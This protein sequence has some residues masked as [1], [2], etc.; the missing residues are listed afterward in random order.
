MPLFAINNS[1]MTATFPGH[2]SF[3]RFD[4]ADVDS[5]I[6]IY[7]I[8]PAAFV[9]VRSFKGWENRGK[10]IRNRRQR[11]GCSQS[12]LNAQVFLHWRPCDLEPQQSPGGGG[13]VVTVSEVAYRAFHRP[14]NRRP[15]LHRRTNRFR[16]HPS[17]PVRS[18]RPR[19]CRHRLRLP[20]RY[21]IQR[22]R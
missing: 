21:S 13:D 12:R 8:W 22:C 6:P 9:I 11:Q 10:T 2:Y 20:N 15:A 14:K 7:F 19:R 4:R 17:R 3:E 18:I 1:K 16:C 5:T